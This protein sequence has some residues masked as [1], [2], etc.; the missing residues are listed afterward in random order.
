MSRVE[1]PVRSDYH[2]WETQ[3][4][5]WVDND[6]Y[7][8]VN[9]AVYYTYIDSVVNSYMIQRGGLDPSSS[10]IIGVVVES[11]CHYRTSF[12]YPEPVEAGLRVWNLGGSSVKYEVGMFR[13]GEDTAAVWGGFVHVFVDRHHRKPV[14]IPDKIRACLKQLLVEL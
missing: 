9:N 11:W 13:Q 14:P 10:D 3:T 2:Q 8:H 7:G 4:T 5:R 12:T 1:A 6:A